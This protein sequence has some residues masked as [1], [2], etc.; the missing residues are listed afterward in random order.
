[1]TTERY[2]FTETDAI[3]PPGELL[4][5]ELETRGMTQ[6]Q[7]AAQMGRPVQAINEIVR[8]KKALTADTALDLERVL[9]IPA[10]LW[11]NLEASYRLALAKAKRP[12][13]ATR[14]GV[15]TRRR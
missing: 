1:M 6:K 13:A 2:E 11:V 8:G 3:I 15:S 14:V 7:L 10:R 9:G 12:A 4:E 5:E